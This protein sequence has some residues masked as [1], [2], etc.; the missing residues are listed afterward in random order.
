MNTHYY[1]ARIDRRDF[2]D[3][4]SEEGMSRLNIDSAAGIEVLE[5]PVGD[6]V[7]AV[8]SVD[9]K[10][11]TQLPA[12]L[13]CQDG[14]QNDWAAWITTYAASIRPFSAYMRLMTNTD[15]QRTA[16]RS[17]TPDIGP[18]TWPATGLILGEVL[19]A[20]GLPD[21]ALE[22][23]SATAFAS[24]L[25]FV[26]CRAAA[27]YADFEEWSYL[28]KTWESV[29]EVTKQRD[30]SVESASIARVCATIM[31]ALGF[32]GAS[33]ILT[34]NDAEVCEACRCLIR[35]PQAIPS[36]LAG[37]KI[38]ADA[39]RMMHGSREDRVVAFEEFLHRSDDISVPKPEV[40]SFML[41]YLASR[42][43]PGTIRH[44]SVLGKIIYRYPTA[45][46]WYGSCSGF[47]EGE[48]N[49][50]NASRRHGVDLPSSARRVIRELLRPEPVLGAPVC[51]IGYL[52]LLAL[53]RTGGNPLEG[54]I[55]TNQGSVIVELLPGVCTSVNVSSKS[56]AEPQMRELR[57]REIIATMGEQIER[58][59]D[60]YKNL[61]AA[62]APGSK[63]EQSS[64]FPSRR[65]KK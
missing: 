22:T 9:P 26:M 8:W 25:S 16:K 50:P 41:G 21:K 4:I 46:L 10:K 52:E 37:I 32:R 39:E 33:K 31:D 15:F 24:T 14:T 28:V 61:L 29:R 7:L 58:L 18:F 1:Y 12:V 60:T 17:P 36:N 35:S 49:I 53:S 47:A 20:S 23:L 45:M 3:L 34:R 38:F 65:K 57:E 40:M 2:G 27:M 62:E 13:I 55:R 43:A 64:L 44:S 56:P 63:T 51:D 5:A 30:R 48:A 54:L 59:R 6:A 11:T 19:G 42:I